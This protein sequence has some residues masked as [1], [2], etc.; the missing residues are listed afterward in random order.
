[1]AEKASV[2][3]KQDLVKII[4]KKTGESIITSQKIVDSMIDTIKEETIKGSSVAIH[5]FGSFVIRHRS[6]RSIISP[7]TKKEM[8]I[9]ASRSVGLRISS[10]YKKMLNS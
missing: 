6:Q 2:I 9:A 10:L 7:S 1:M 4:A 3:Y 5:K 8:Q